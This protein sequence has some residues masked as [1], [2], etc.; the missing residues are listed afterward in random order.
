MAQRKD[1]IYRIIL[2]LLS[3][4]MIVLSCIFLTSL[5]RA[6]KVIVIFLFTVGLVIFCLVDSKYK[7]PLRI[8]TVIIVGASIIVVVY[9]I[10]EKFDWIKYLED[11]DSIRNF[12][13]STKQWGIITFLVLTIL[14]VVFLPI[15][16]AVTILIGVAIYGPLMAFVLSLVGTYIG[17]IICFWIGK[18]CGKKLVAW[19]VG[20]D[21]AEKYAKMLNDKGKWI[22]ALML[23]FPFFP[24]DT[25][26]LVAGTTT[27]SWK[28]FLLA[29]LFTRP[30]IIAF[31]S[32][33]GSGEIIP[34]SGWGIPV[35][36]GIFILCIVL[37]IIAAKLKN[38]IINSLE[39]KKN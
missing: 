7:I 37:L 14:Q 20:K 39:K 8:T 13:L 9:M 33:F 25:L 12:I 16:A 31:T 22:F 23:L 27:M 38:K 24:D 11:F 29:M 4:A 18:S 19:M 35:W 15:P 5:H 36:I 17:S 34:Y 28:F 30:L 2:A 1:F 32:F 6:I 21:S 3:A 26:C 10:A